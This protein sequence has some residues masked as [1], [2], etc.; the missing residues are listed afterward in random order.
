MRAFVEEVRD[1]LRKG[2]LVCMFPE[3]GVSGNGLIL[4]FKRGIARIMPE[5][6]E[7]PLIPI[8]LGMLWGSLFSLD[9]RGKLHF[10]LP[11]QFPMPILIHVGKPVPKEMTPFQLRQKISELSAEIEMER[12][13]SE[14]PVH[15]AFVR[16]TKHRPFFSVYRDF[17]GARPSNLK[18]LI[19]ALVLSRIVRELDQ[20]YQSRYIGV[21]MPNCTYAAAL[22]HAVLFADRTPAILN[23]SAGASAREH[24]IRNAGIRIILTSRKF[25]EKLGWEKTPEMIFLE[26]LAGKATPSL[27]RRVL[28][29]VIFRT[30]GSLMRKYAPETWNDLSRE[31]VLLFSSGSTGIPKGIMLTHHNVNS[32]FFSFWRVINWSPKDKVV[33]NLPLFHAYGFIVGFVIECYI[34]TPVV[35]I[36]NP[37]DASGVCSLCE[38]EKPTLMMATPTF[39]QHYMRKY[40]PGQFQSLRLVITGAEKL[41]KDIADKFRALTGLAITEGFGCTE[42]SPI[43]S[44]NFSFSQ[45][46]MGREAGVKDSVGAPLPGVHVKIVDP[47]TFEELPENT[48]GLMLV[49]GGN[50]MKGYLNEP[51]KTAEVIRNG[52]YNTGDIA[53]MSPDGYLTITGRLARFSKIAGEMVP[54]ELIELAI[55]EILGAEERVVAVCGAKDEKRGERLC[56][57]YTGDVLIPEQMIE[58]LKKRGLPNLW[59]PKVSDFVKLEKI[60]L[61]GSGK[62]D[63]EA[64]RRMAADL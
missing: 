9:K 37:L 17:N 41:R 30:P 62:L 28:L 4:R 29:D 12:H 53:S 36:T 24:S 19:S 22:L 33:G 44:V 23:F 5:D 34:P 26:D 57:F 63:L 45:W 20:P 55:N 56:V 42:T 59:I 32:N 6:T 16:L 27:K 52:F 15:Y 18:M 35:Y 47:E 8:S 1:H 40:K 13:Q 64:I 48:P 11:R 39:L 10:T 54:H 43:V 38:K 2:D 21:L 46:D 7:V 3:G 61:L 51:E 60:P 25:I 14:H 31:C 50:V 49:K 58:S